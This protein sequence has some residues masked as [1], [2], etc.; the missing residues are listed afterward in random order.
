[1]A[2]GFTG[3]NGA[4]L[5][6]LIGSVLC[7][8]IHIY[9][10]RGSLAGLASLAVAALSPRCW[11]SSCCPGGLRRHPCPGLRR[12]PAA[13]RLLRP[14]RELHHRA[15]HDPG[16]GQEPLP[17]RQRHRRRTGPDEGDVRGQPGAVRQGGPQRLPRDAPRTRPDRRAGAA[18]ARRR[19]PRPLLAA[20]ERQT[21]AACDGGGGPTVLAADRDRPGHGGGRRLLRGAALPAPVD[22]AR[23]RRCPGAVHAGPAEER[24]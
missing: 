7:L 2:M 13:P 23:D 10:R 12:R 3:S 15:R 5:T 11:W 24:G 16:R 8:S 22:L 20:A 19:R 1:M 21:A 14:Q 4:M 6:L 17:P 9:H 18:A